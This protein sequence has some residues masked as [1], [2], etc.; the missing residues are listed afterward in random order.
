MDLESFAIAVLCLVEEM[1]ADS[2]AEPAWRRMRGRGPA[3]TLA[4]SEV[5]TMEVSASSSG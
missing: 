5:L 2:Q 3:P 1:L 4:D